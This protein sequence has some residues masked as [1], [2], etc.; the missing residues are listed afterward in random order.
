MH[1]CLCTNSNWHA[2]NLRVQV[3][4]WITSWRVVICC[5]TLRKPAW[6]HTTSRQRFVKVGKSMFFFFLTSCDHFQGAWCVRQKLC[7][8]LW[9]LEYGLHPL[10]DV[11]QDFCVMKVFNV[12]LIHTHPDFA[13]HSF[14]LLFWTFRPKINVHPWWFCFHFFP[15]LS[16]RKVP[17]DAPDLTLG[18][19]IE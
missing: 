10:W 14:E 9:Y 4:S 16:G 5:Q 12:P 19:M 11:C 1:S 7:L 8:E 3:I 17:F 6:G 13:T 18:W 15:L 2:S